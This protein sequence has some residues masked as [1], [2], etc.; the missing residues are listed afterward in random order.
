VEDQAMAEEIDPRRV[1]D[2]A[3]RREIQ[4]LLKVK[5]RYTAKLRT[6]LAERDALLAERDALLTL[7]RQRQLE[8]GRRTQASRGETQPP[9]LPRPR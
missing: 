3:A 6:L 9:L 7:H 2:P 8:L 1:T 5:A 4:R